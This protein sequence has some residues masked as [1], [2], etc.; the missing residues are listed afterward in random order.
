MS[1]DYLV[2]RETHAWL[3]TGGGQGVTCFAVPP[4]A[5][6]GTTRHRGALLLGPGDDVA[7][8]WAPFCD[9]ID[10]FGHVDK[11]EF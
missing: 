2:R 7:V 8:E 5:G 1:N 3:C 10:I 4:L 6:R 9:F 11:I